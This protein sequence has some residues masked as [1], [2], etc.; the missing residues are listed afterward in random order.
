MSMS[1]HLGHI[2]SGTVDRCWVAPGVSVAAVGKLSIVRSSGLKPPIQRRYFS[3]IVHGDT[4][5]APRQPL[6]Q[7]LAEIIELLAHS[8]EPRRAVLASFLLDAAGDFRD[9]LAAA[10]NQA[11][12][13]NMELRRA[14]PLSI[15]GRMAMTLYVWS[16]SA[17]RQSLAAR[18]HTR[19]VMMTGRETSRRL[20]ELEYDEHDV[21]TGAHLTQVS[22]EGLPA[23]ELERVRA[24]SLVLQRQRLQKAL[25][26]GK[27]GRNDPCPCGS[28]DKFK[29]CHDRR[30]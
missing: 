11:L 17:P 22:L 14:R 18:Q 3:A 26:S 24:A 21:L 4:R 12:R 10:I 9:Q 28:G 27:I 30:A 8:T 15:Y 5:R 25:T 2:A 23:A 13:E 20:V 1:C 16:P 29:R 19:A 6:P 7:R